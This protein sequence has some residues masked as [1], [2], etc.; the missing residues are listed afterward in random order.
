MEELELSTAPRKIEGKYPCL[1]EAGQSQIET[2]LNAKVKDGIKLNKRG[3]NPKLPSKIKVSQKEWDIYQ[4]HP[5]VVSMYECYGPEGQEIKEGIKNG[6][7]S[8][9]YKTVKLEIK[10]A[11]AESKETKLD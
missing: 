4:L 2:I 10:K 3:L 11:H 8:L 6:T 7:V 1:S 5:D 9:T